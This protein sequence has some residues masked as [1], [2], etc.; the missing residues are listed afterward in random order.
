MCVRACVSSEGFSRYGAWGARAP[1]QGVC[2][3]GAVRVV[4]ARVLSV[5]FLVAENAQLLA[6]F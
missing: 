5:G 6:K 2:G 1:A 3:S 4:V